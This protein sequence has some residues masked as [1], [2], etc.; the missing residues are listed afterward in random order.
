[1]IG[2]PPHYRSQCLTAEVD[3]KVIGIGGFLFPPGGD[4]W[5]SVLMIDEARKYRLAIHRAGLMAMELARKRGFRRV[6][7]TAQPDNPAAE[8]W[9]ERLG[10]RAGDIA[11]EKVFIWCARTTTSM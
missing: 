2:Q 6:Y 7:A 8:R 4:V 1:L 9:L 11:G 3:G 10:F 5:A